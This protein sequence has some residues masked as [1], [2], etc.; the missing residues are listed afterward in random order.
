MNQPTPAPI[1]DI[2]GPVWFWPYPLWMTIGVAV[3]ALIL[4]LGVI[5]WWLRRKPS[6][7]KSLMPR[8]AALRDL[9]ELAARLAGMEPYAFGIAVSEALRRYLTRQHGLPATTQTSQEF[10]A[11]LASRFDPSIKERLSAFLERTDLLKFAR[12]EAAEAEMREVLDTARTIINLP[13][14]AEVSSK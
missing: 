7:L 3:L 13:S 10:L 4:F 6:R 5:V 9:D 11:G 8:E 12:A 1:E 14:P 2:V